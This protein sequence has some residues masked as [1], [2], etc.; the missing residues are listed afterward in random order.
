MASLSDLEE[1]NERLRFYISTIDLI[2][3]SDVYKSTFQFTCPIVLGGFSF[4]KYYRESLGIATQYPY[5]MTDDIDFKIYL[6]FDTPPDYLINIYKAL[7]H[8]VSVYTYDLKVFEQFHLFQRIPLSDCP[9][10]ITMQTG[11]TQRVGNF[12]LGIDLS[13]MNPSAYSV[14]GSYLIFAQTDFDGLRRTMDTEYTHHQ[15]TQYNIIYLFQNIVQS[16]TNGSFTNR[17]KKIG[18][19]FMRYFIMLSMTDKNE[20]FLNKIL[21]LINRLHDE[22]NELSYTRKIAF[23]NERWRLINSTFGLR[24]MYCTGMGVFEE[25]TNYAIAINNI[26]IIDMAAGS[27]ADQPFVKITDEVRIVVQTMAMHARQQIEEKYPITDIAGGFLVTTRESVKSHSLLKTKKQQ[28][29]KSKPLSKSTQLHQKMHNFTNIPE[30]SMDELAAIIID[31]VYND[32]KNI[33]KMLTYIT[34]CKP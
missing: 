5:I 18:S 8:Y 13:V 11:D 21:S 3:Q 34:D 1:A 2:L 15:L 22:S 19:V 31:C 10:M 30:S 17:F 29:L 4:I 9:M 14:V 25:M 16:L 24:Y 6:P 27:K 32:G 7:I 20:D 12:R 33:G 26:N 28:E 23:Y